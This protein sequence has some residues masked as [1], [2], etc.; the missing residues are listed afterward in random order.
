MFFWAGCSSSPRLDNSFTS[1]FNGKNLSGWEGDESEFFRVE[2]H[3][4]VIGKADKAVEFNHYL[5]SENEYENFELHVQAKLNNDHHANSGV[6]FRSVDVANE[7]EIRGY[8][9][10]VGFHDGEIIWG[11]LWDNFRR[12]EELAIEAPDVLKKLYR[13]GDWNDIVVRCQ[14]NRIQ[15]W[16]NGHKTVDYIEKE[17][18]IESSGFI[19]FQ[20]HT[21]DPSEVYY[22]NIY[23]KEL[24]AKS[25]PISTY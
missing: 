23:I 10:D 13:S 24:G 25:G 16:F 21:G 11:N 6:Q 17:D 7:T 20:V 5:I 2:D 3:V 15:I 18:G 14:G 9:A 4:I 8:Q 19:G 22:R 1:L 12:D